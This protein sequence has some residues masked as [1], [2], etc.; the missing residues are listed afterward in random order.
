MTFTLV[1]LYTLHL[2]TGPSLQTTTSPALLRYM[3]AGMP[4]GSIIIGTVLYSVSFHGIVIANFH[5]KVTRATLRCHPRVFKFRFPAGC[6]RSVPFVQVSTFP[7]SERPNNFVS[8]KNLDTP[9]PF[10]ILF[11]IFAT[12]FALDEYTASIEH[13]WNSTCGHYN[14]FSVLIN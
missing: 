14:I 11:I 9:H 1:G 7:L 5:L 6:I 2:H 4:L 3:I 10:E 13:G 12:A 8:D